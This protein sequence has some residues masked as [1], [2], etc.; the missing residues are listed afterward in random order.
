M[1]REKLEPGRGM[2]FIFDHP[3]HLEFW[4]HNTYIPLD[5]IFIGADKRVVGVIEK[6]APLTNDPRGVE[7]N[8]LYVLE[9][10]GGYATAHRIGPG[11]QV[12]LAAID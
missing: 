2:L 12:E 4:M 8:S 11:I 6:A 7:G 1:Y 5:M 9:V 3:Q 10:P